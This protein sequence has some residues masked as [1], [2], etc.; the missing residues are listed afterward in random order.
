MLYWFPP[1]AGED[2]HA[3]GD[4]GEHCFG[5]LGCLALPDAFFHAVHRPINLPP[6]RREEV[7]VVFTVHAREDPQGT[8]VPAMHVEGV[9]NSS[10]SARRPTKVI[11][12]G[13]LDH[14]GVTWM[15][16]MVRALLA[17]Q[18]LNVVTVDWS[19]GSQ[20]LYSQATANTRL[21]ALEVAHLIHFLQ[22]KV[23]LEPR[24]VHIIG[25][26]L[27]S[28]TAGYVGERVLGLGRITGLDPAEPFFQF[29]PPAVRL[30]PSDALLVDVIHTDADSIFNFGA[31]FGMRQPVGHIDFYPNDGRS[32]PGCDSLARVPLTALTDGLSLLEGLDAAQ[33]EFVACH[34]NRAAKLFTDSILSRCPYTAFHCASYTHYLKGKCVSCGSED[35]RCARLGLPAD[36]WRGTNNTKQVSL[37]LSTGQ[38]PHYCRE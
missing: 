36:R 4:S 2:T 29:M 13:F 37:Y 21:V 33:K 26:S 30:D 5:E 9:L 11:I 8:P 32:Q 38:G 25:H 14:T 23:A 27:G 28:H 7:G 34:H 20:A 18:D 35:S 15:L 12:H 19:G 6:Y 31:G 16:D 24:H 1:A 3:G 22:D 10:F 17:A